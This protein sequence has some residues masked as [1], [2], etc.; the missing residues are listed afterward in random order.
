M[1]FI[2][3]LVIFDIAF[4]LYVVHLVRHTHGENYSHEPR[5]KHAHVSVFDDIREAEEDYIPS[6]RKSRLA[7]WEARNNVQ[8]EAEVNVENEAREMNTH[9]RN[10]FAG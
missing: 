9:R 2:I 7:Q 10:M 1:A 3:F 4:I 5:H 6:S 8:S